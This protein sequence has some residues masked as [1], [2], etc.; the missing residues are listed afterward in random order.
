VLQA[1]FWLLVGHALADYPLQGDWLSK[2]KNHTLADKL[3]PGQT[4]WFLALLSHAMIHAGFV[5]LI[6]GSYALGF[7]EFICHAVIDDAKC[8]G[9]LTYN[10]DQ[11]LHI[12]CKVIYVLL[13]LFVGQV[14]LVS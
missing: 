2:A 1:L 4:I 9:G 3:V 8:D 13:M 14:G 12:G 5:V 11:L 6:T 10:Q 7:V